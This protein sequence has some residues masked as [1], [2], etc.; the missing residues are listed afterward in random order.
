MDHHCR[1]RKWAVE[2]AQEE[3]VC[4]ME[5]Q[6]WEQVCTEAW[7]VVVALA[8]ACTEALVVE[9]WVWACIEAWAADKLAW[10]LVEV[11]GTWALALVCTV[12]WLVGV[13]AC[14]EVLVV[15]VVVAFWVACMV[16]CWESVVVALACR[17][18]LEHHILPEVPEG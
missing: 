16:V 11:G 15:E 17:L 10:E 13:L 6:A 9:A 4:K 5:R 8:W 7:A 1:L 12:A 18:A 14:I 2:L 3:L